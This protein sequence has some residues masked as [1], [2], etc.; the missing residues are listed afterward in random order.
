[1]LASWKCPVCYWRGG[2]H[3]PGCTV[4][5]LSI[6]RPDRK[7]GPRAIQL[8]VLALKAY[9]AAETPLEAK[10]AGILLDLFAPDVAE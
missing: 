10:M 5:H 6:F 7:P 9:H 2:N 4:Q 1:M 3:A 8:R